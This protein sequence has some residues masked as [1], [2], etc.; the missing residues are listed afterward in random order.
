MEYTANGVSREFKNAPYTL[1]STLRG[2]GIQ[3]AGHA[4]VPEQGGLTVRFP[5]GS[6]IFTDGSM[7]QDDN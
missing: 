3:E 4:P 7:D 1:R 5:S 6:R 2:G